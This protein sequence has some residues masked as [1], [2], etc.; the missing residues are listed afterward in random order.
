MWEFVKKAPDGWHADSNPISNQAVARRSARAID[1]AISSH[2]L[3]KAI[4]AP[5][6]DGD[7][8][9]MAKQD[10]QIEFTVFAQQLEDEWEG[11]KFDPVV[12]NE[13]AMKA[14]QS[15]KKDAESVALLAQVRIV[16][17][18]LALAWG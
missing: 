12:P 2:Y 5:G 10:G 11:L 15:E 17:L 4:G 14:V 7:R 8:W 3:L 9:G 18:R 16:W 13:M 6:I 1:Y